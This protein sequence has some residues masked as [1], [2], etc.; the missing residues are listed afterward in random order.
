TDD[1][2]A[3]NVAKVISD[4]DKP[5]PQVLINVVFLEATYADSL[6]LGVE[7]TYHGGNSGTTATVPNSFSTNIVSTISSNITKTVTNIVPTTTTIPA[8]TGNQ[9]FNL[10]G[11]TTGG[12]YTVAGQNYTA[13]LHALAQAGKL[14]VLSRPSIL[15]RNNQQA[16]IVVGQQVPLITGVNYDN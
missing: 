15:T 7:G 11:Q 3:A 2:T 12:I 14:E 13:T 1:E 10:A 16:S 5:K 9:N 8:F 6:D 4:L